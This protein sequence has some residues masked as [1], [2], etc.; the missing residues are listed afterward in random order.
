MSILTKKNKAIVNDQKS[1]FLV[2]LAEKYAYWT[3]KGNMEFAQAYQHM[4]CAF[5]QPDKKE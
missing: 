5:T 3:K 1:E 2:E 4:L